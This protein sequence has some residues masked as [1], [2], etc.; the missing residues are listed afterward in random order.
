VPPEV[1]DQERIKQ[2]CAYLRMILLRSG[3][4]RDLWERRADHVEPSKITYAAVAAVLTE[5]GADGDPRELVRGALDGTDLTPAALSAFVSAFRLSARDATRLRNLLRGSESVR[6]IS[7]DTVTPSDLFRDRQPPRHE[8]LALHELHVLGPDGFPAEHQSIQVIK[9][10]VDRMESFPLIFDTDEVVV[11]VIRGGRL[12]D[13]VFRVTETMYGVD[14]VLSEPLARDETVMLQIRFAFHYKS[15]PRPEF[16]R[17]VLRSTKDATIWVR[18]H[19]DRLPV[20]VCS[21]RWDRLD[22]AKVVE[23][24]EVELDAEHSVQCRYDAIDRAIVGFYWDFG[25]QDAAR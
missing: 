7:G 20:R 23:E 14:I 2:A 24:T 22:L 10:T 6:V 18:F 11:E 8:T 12:G 5:G 3:E 15:P 9:S 4:Y 25:N 17:A 16:R 1:S 21:A 19:P 13:D